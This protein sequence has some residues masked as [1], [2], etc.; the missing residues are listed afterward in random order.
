MS[1]RLVLGFSLIALI[2]AVLIVR[3]VLSRDASAREQKQAPAAPSGQPQGGD[4]APAQGGRPGAGGMGPQVV[5]VIVAPVEKRDVPI[6][7][8][9][10]GTVM[11]WQQVTVKPQVDGVLLSVKFR[12]GQ[13]VKAGDILAEIDPRPF[14]VQVHQAEGALS[15]DQSA[16]TN[17]K[18]N[19]ERYRKLAAD[20]F[21]AMQQATDQEAVVAQAEGAIKVDQAAVEAARLN[22][23]YTK[24]KS[25]LDGT[26]G[27]RLVDAGNQ[28]HTTD[29][30]GLV[31]ITQI[32]PAAVM[33]T[34]PQDNLPQIM[35]ALGRGAVPVEAWSRDGAQRLA[36]GNVY[37]VDN[38]INVATGT[39]RIKA[40]VA[41]ADRLLWPNAFV[42]ARVLVET[43]KDAIV[44]P[45]QALQRG[46]QGTFVYVAQ[47][48][49]T[50]AQ[51]PVKVSLATGD[52]AVV[53]DGLKA[54]EKVI[55]EGQNQL[56]P[57]A[58]IAVRPAK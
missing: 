30:T 31:V 24:I 57:G 54:G 5:Q 34:L 19:L 26:A 21:I 53:T 39:V 17:G 28:I 1:R 13:A 11:A 29:A 36:L 48:D 42:K 8:D 23:D 43:A 52:I 20:K 56:R 12:E 40:Q 32:D 35:A 18:L 49:N 22:L 10:L 55:T 6:W 7:L 9:G 51:R 27:V 3:A 44:V 38:Q 15:R 25:P 47:A 41:N 2:G 33:I 46:P 14:L 45:A 4:A 16:V 50:A 37:A 58:K